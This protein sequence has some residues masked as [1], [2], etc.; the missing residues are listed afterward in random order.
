MACNYLHLINGL[1]IVF[2]YSRKQ[3][4]IYGLQYLITPK[5]LYHYIK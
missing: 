3:D 4:S 1:Y 2:I 5:V